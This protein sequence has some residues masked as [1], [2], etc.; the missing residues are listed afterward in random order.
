MTENNN[1]LA[2]AIGALAAQETR[3]AV[4]KDDQVT[5]L[6]DLQQKVLDE[7]VVVRWCLLILVISLGLF[8]GFVLLAAIVK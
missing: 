1:L 6:I 2:A 8:V 4:D 5:K 3:K 7:L